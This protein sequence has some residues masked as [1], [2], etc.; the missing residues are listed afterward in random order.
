MTIPIQ[1]TPPVNTVI[2]IQPVTT[3]IPNRESAPGA[4]PLANVPSGTTIAGFV[5]N[6]DAQSNPILRTPLGDLRITSDVFLKTGSEVVFRVDTTQTSLARIV[7]VDGLSPQEYSAQSSRGLTQDTIS[8]SALQLPSANALA[9]AAKAGGA[10]PSAPVLNAIVLQPSAPLTPQAPSLLAAAL[11]AAQSGP[12]S[13]LTQLSQLRTGAALKLTVLDLK[14]PP[15]PVALSSLPESGALSQLLGPRPANPNAPSAANAPTP[16]LPESG[17]NIATIIGKPAAN[18]SAEI[19]TT[20]TNPSPPLP[21]TAA[22]TVNAPSSPPQALS[23]LPPQTGPFTSNSNVPSASPQTQ[24]L[25]VTQVATPTIPTQQ[26]SVNA[27]PANTPQAPASNSPATQANAAPA[28]PELARPTAANQL[29]A[30]VIG[31]DADGAN[32]LHTPFASLKIYTPQPL[33]TGTTLLVRADIATSTGATAIVDAPEVLATAAAL[34]PTA[35]NLGSLR[36]TLQWLQTNQPDVAR[37]AL[38]RLPSI[39][40]Q[41]TNGLLSYIA[42]IKAGETAEIIGKRALRFLEINAPDILAR[43]GGQI[44]QLQGNYLE[45]RLPQWSS[46]PLPLLLGGEL[47]IAQLYIGKDAPEGDKFT[48]DKGRGQRFILEV[49]MS[50]LGPLQFDGFVRTLDK[51]KSFD[52]MVRSNAALPA[53]VDAGIRTIFTSSMEITGLRGQVIFQHGPQHFIRPEAGAARVLG[54]DGNTIL[55]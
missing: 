12:L 53:D 47:H 52:L 44:E 54:H 40:H 33:P 50:Q 46:L 51:T 55:A 42:G 5:V 30:S 38:S 2:T 48:S 16:T 15:L 19:K 13:I 18:V 39:G 4:N 31:H 24:P 23:S 1:S 21:Q 41:L 9:Q 36:E 35:A 8:S 28:A 29:V 37:D 32:I 45:S 11:S 20:A 22:A 3:T 26:T 34:P 25:V 49:E 17:E 10:N 43:L 27:Q 14:L 6:R 7:T